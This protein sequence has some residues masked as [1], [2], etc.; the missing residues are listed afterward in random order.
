MSRPT[1]ICVTRHGET[2]WNTSGILQGWLD[3]PMNERGRKQSLELADA[4][5][6]SG[7]TCVYASPLQRALECAQIIATRLALPPPVVHSGIRER[8]FGVIQGI[9]KAEL[10][11]LNPVLFGQILKR[12]PAAS[13]EQGESMDDVATRVLAA[14]TDIAE[15]R[16][17]ER[18]LVITHGWAMDVVVRHVHNLPRSAILHAKPRNGECVWLEATPGS[19]R[20]LPRDLR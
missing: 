12:N 4:F 9:P 17:G 20:A 19:I 6:A 14:M 7:F 5:A 15:Q 13:F 16:A 1:E 3:V 2:D 18:V 11:E 8:N 10:A